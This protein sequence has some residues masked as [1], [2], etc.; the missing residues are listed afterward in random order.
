[1]ANS[2]DSRSLTWWRIR[3]VRRD[4]RRVRSIL[5]G[6]IN[7]L[8]IDINCTLKGDQNCFTGGAVIKYLMILQISA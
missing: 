1:M 2:G 5:V 7:A 3:E 8:N 4:C 6:F